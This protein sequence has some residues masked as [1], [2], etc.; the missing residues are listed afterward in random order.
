MRIAFRITISQPVA[1]ILCVLAIV[2]ATVALLS[3]N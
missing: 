1:A 3:P 2:L